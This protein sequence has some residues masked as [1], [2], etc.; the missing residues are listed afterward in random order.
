MK[1][2]EQKTQET[3]ERL[4]WEIPKIADQELSQLLNYTLRDASWAKCFT[5][6]INLDAFIDRLSHKRLVGKLF[7]Q[8]EDANWDKALRDAV[9]QV[10]LLRGVRVYDVKLGAML[11]LIKEEGE[12]DGG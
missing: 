4:G 9:A 8:T 2:T 10:I 6:V 12:T 3:L 7:H 5:I 11:E 1:M